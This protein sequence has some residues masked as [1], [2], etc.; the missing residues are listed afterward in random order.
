MENL[1]ANE[2]KDSQGN[3]EN[4][5]AARAAEEVVWRTMIDFPRPDELDL[6]LAGTHLVNSPY[7][8]LSVR[9]DAKQ[10]LQT[11][12]VISISIP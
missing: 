1:L 4:A 5:A 8:S 9:L 6:K 3:T 11:P 10:G 7:E 2:P 12:L